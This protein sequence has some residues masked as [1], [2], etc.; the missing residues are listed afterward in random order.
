[1][2]ENF[3]HIT[4]GV[5]IIGIENPELALAAERFVDTKADIDLFNRTAAG[6]AL[7]NETL[8]EELG[9]QTTDPYGYV[10]SIL[11]F[12]QFQRRDR[13]ERKSRKA[14]VP[15]KITI[16][17]S[18]RW[19]P[20]YRSQEQ[21]DEIVR[22]AFDAFQHS[23][24]D[25]AAYECAD[26]AYISKLGIV[27]AHE[28]KNR[29]ALFRELDLNIPAV[30]HEED[31]PDAARI[32]LFKLAEGDF[33]VL[34]DKYVERVRSLDIATEILGP[35]GVSIEEK[36]P[37]SYPEIARIVN[38]MKNRHLS[39]D[40]QHRTLDMTPVHQTQKADETIVKAR[41]TEMD[42]PLRPT[43]DFFLF[44]IIAGFVLAIVGSQSG[45][46]PVFQG[47][48]ATLLLLD[49][50]IVYLFTAPIFSCQVQKL[51]DERR[52]EVR[53]RILSGIREQ[54][55]AAQSSPNSKRYLPG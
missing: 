5:P 22:R 10:Y 46:W 13:A 27:L 19:T 8:R 37:T 32:R 6:R 48:I 34:D 18:W 44:T 40:L 54:E 21:K 11:P 23:T 30:V 4:A 28:G 15:P 39:R 17:Q 12:F 3:D 29:V 24:D 25:K 20:A 36:W 47:I 35:Y 43:K 52:F 7:M 16:G 49:I 42:T 26:Y 14:M 9:Y 53:Y 41:L 51:I 31:Y 55:K 1:M 50:G 45:M 38:A 2:L 33:A